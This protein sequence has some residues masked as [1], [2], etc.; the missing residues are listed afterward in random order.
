MLHIPLEISSGA[1]GAYMT[2]EILF[3]ALLAVD[4]RQGRPGSW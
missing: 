1:L 3:A 4:P 2:P